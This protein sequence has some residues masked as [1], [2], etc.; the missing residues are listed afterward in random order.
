M[1][2]APTLLLLFEV[3]QEEVRS[4]FDELLSKS[5]DIDLGQAERSGDSGSVLV[6]RGLTFQSEWNPKGALVS[7][8]RKVFSA[9]CDEAVRSVLAVSPHAHIAGGLAVPEIAKI[10]LQFGAICARTLGAVAVVWRST[11]LQSSTDYFAEVVE[12]Y[13]AGGVFP[14]LPIVDFAFEE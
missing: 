13:A 8:R 2:I 14:V 5:T 9:L 4:K 3:S 10:F 6:F 12:S 11:A 7:E 1:E